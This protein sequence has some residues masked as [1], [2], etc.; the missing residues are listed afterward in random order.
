MK[1]RGRRLK[2]GEQRGEEDENVIVGKEVEET[3]K[4]N[5]GERERNTWVEWEFASEGLCTF[6]QKKFRTNQHFPFSFKKE[7]DQEIHCC[8]MT[9]LNIP[10]RT[11]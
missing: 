1:K 2:N 4:R 7:K 3:R 6:L 5:E 8:F 9:K 11:S 10:T